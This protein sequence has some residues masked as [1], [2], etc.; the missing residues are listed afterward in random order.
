MTYTEEEQKKI[1][2]V[3]DLMRGGPKKRIEEFCRS[4]GVEYTELIEHAFEYIRTEGNSYW[5][6][7]GRFEGVGLYENFWADFELVTG[8][9]VPSE[10][11]NGWG[12]FSCSC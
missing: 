12:F 4:I 10:T 3:R 1:D 5:S 9:V 7:G 11:K 6:E 8:T 2:A